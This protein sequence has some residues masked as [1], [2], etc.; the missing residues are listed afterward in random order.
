MPSLNEMIV[1]QRFRDTRVTGIAG[2]GFVQRA[3]GDS[4]FLQPY[5]RCVAEAVVLVCDHKALV[6]LCDREAVVVLCDREAV[7][8]P[9]GSRI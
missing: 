4:S 9:S 7:N 6:V 5:L 1:L 2:A 3:L 8:A